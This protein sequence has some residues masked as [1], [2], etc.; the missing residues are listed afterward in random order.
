VLQRALDD[1][2]VQ[3]ELVAA[4]ENPV[5]RPLVASA[6]HARIQDG[7]NAAGLQIM[8]PH[9]ALQPRKPVLAEPPPTAVGSQGP[10]GDQNVLASP[11]DR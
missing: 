10:R 9:F 2:Y 6:L 3:Y 7:F 8:S 5:D 11:A 1:F 4:V